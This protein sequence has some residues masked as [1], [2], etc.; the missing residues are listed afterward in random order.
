MLAR[1]L[2]S[3]WLSDRNCLFGPIIAAGKMVGQ[4][5]RLRRIG[6]RDTNS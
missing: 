4:N 3:V 5:L 1:W 6:L 2:D